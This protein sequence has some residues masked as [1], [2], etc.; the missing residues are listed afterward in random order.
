[1]NAKL[2][3]KLDTM[4]IEKTKRYA[5]DRGVSLSRLVETFFAG[6]LRE[7]SEPP[8]ATGVVAELAGLLEGADIEDAHE[9]YAEYLAHKYS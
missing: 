2:T 5:A 8:N 3:L 1:M 4:V 7:A 9:E 6:L